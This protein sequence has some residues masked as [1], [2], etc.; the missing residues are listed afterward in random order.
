[1]YILYLANVYTS[2]ILLFIVKQLIAGIIKL[3]KFVAPLIVVFYT[4]LFV[5]IFPPA[6]P[7][8]RIGP[9]Y[10]LLVVKGD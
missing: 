10:P 6:G 2:V 7:G 1:M 3:F 4:F 9:L 8:F 5:S